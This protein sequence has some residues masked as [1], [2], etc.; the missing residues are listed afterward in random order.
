MRELIVDLDRSLFAPSHPLAPCYDSIKTRFEQEGASVEL[1]DSVIAPPLVRFRRK[2]KAAWNAEKRH[3]VPLD[4]EEVRRE[5]MVIIYVDAKQVVEQ[6]QDGGEAGL[7][8]W[9]SDLKRWIEVGNEGQAEE[10]SHLQ[11]FLICQGLVKY[12]SRLRANENRA[13]TARIRQQLAENQN[14]ASQAATAPP[15][16]AVR[17]KATVATTGDAGVRADHPPQSAVER[18][19]L[20]LKLV[21]R[22][23]VIHA[24]SL[25]DGIEWLHQL[26]S[27]L[28]LKPYKSLR[29]THLSFAVDTGRHTTSASSAHIYTTMLQ[30]IPRVT[31]AIANSIT[32]IYPS[33]QMLLQAYQ[34]CTDEKE[35]QR[36]L[37]GV[38]VQSNKDGTERRG[39]RMNLGLQLSKRIH[40]VLRGSNGDLLINNPTKD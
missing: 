8:R 34:R 12:Y 28:S 36:L 29:D 30:Q 32:T 16:S 24:A 35:Q 13:Y 27:D 33:L 19:L 6:V 17:P 7:E 25:V 18:G 10:H 20:Q 26:A 15:K 22:C 3:W 23:Y 14:D 1:Y 5:G 11:V 40:A 21:H 37:S 2:V 39:N 4:T 9:Y 31:P 38:Q